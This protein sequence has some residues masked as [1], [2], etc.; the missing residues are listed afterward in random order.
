M[1]S[2]SWSELTQIK[3]VIIYFKLSVWTWFI[4][5]RWR[6]YSKYYTFRPDIYIYIAFAKH[7]LLLLSMGL[8]LLRRSAYPGIITC[9]DKPHVRALSVVKF[10]FSRREMTT[11]NCHKRN[12]IYMHILYYIGQ[13]YVNIHNLNNLVLRCIFFLFTFWDCVQGRCQG[14]SRFR[15]YQAGVGYSYKL[16]VCSQKFTNLYRKYT[17]FFGCDIVWALPLGKCLEFGTS[18]KKGYFKKKNKKTDLKGNT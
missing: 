12:N 18:F 7:S 14:H 1:L 5:F 6:V 2:A 15:C 3:Y 16:Y 13:T 11:R 17:C 10:M 9:K 4:L 8:S